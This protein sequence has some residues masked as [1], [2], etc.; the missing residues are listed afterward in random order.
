MLFAGVLTA[1]LLLRDAAASPVTHVEVRHIVQRNIISDISSLANEA[2]ADIGSLLSS[3]G[4]AI[5]SYVASG[6]PN[7]FQN[8]PSGSAVQSSLSLSD[9]QVTGLPVNVLN[10]P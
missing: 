8:F 7:F 9:A 4:S 6:V 5:P 10:L 2:T 3:L 1:A